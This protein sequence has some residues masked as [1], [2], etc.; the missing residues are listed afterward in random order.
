MIP[1]DVID[2]NLIEP[3][4]TVVLKLLT[5]L[6]VTDRSTSDDRNEHRHGEHHRR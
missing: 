2:D 6:F 3:S 4:E 1:V 5:P